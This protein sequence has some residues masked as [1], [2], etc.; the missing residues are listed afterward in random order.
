MSKSIGFN[1]VMG[2]LW[3]LSAIVMH[4]QNPEAWG[5]I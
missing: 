2:I 3:T 4:I 5:A 1:L